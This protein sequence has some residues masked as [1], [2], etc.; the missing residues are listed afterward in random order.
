MSARLKFHV[1]LWLHDHGVR[2]DNVY[3]RLVRLI[4][5]KLRYWSFICDGVRHIHDDEVVPEVPYVTILG[6]MS[7]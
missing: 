3:P 5:R 6:R 7:K 4:P 2:E 1:R